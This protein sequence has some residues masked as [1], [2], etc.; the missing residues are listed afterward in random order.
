MGEKF[1]SKGVTSFSLFLMI[2]GL[3][4]I[5]IYPVYTAIDY[6]FKI[7][8]ELFGQYG[9]FVGG[10][11]GSL[12]SLAAALLL[13]KTLMTQIKAFDLQKKELEFQSEA[14]RIERFE[15]TFFNLLSTNRD[16]AN[17]IKTYVFSLNDELRIT[18]INAD[19]REF[20]AYAKE[21]LK[22]LWISINSK[23]YLGKYNSDRFE[24]FN[25][26]LEELRDINSS[27][28]VGNEN[29]E[30]AKTELIKLE[31][32]K[33]SN[34]FYGVTKEIWEKAQDLNTFNKMNLVYTLFF[35]K[36]NYAIGH[37]FRHLYQIISYTNHY[38]QSDRQSSENNAKKY[39]DF[40][41]AQ[42]STNE[43]IIV[44][45]YSIIF[46]EF[47]VFLTKFNF[48]EN[49]TIED[50]IHQ[51]HNCIRGISLK[52]SVNVSENLN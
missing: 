4:V 47:I 24:A 43:L 9:D 37:Y 26:D 35:R 17:S 38:F 46:P 32:L 42:I 8:P 3:I 40:L 52:S 13:Y 41:H 39:I 19:G 25:N 2:V 51:S 31:R 14:N 49:L 34:H 20:F 45:Y 36:Y 5:I 50:L 27:N 10:I 30:Y 11:V 28:Y 15:T 7:K 6:P 29:F 21:E 48:L 33:Y 1:L 18:K 22:N 16:I 44:F 23:T 12:F